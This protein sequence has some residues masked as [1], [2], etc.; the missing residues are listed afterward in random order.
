MA[1]MKRLHGTTNI[2]YGWR[3]GDAAKSHVE[4][5]PAG[6]QPHSFKVPTGEKIIDDFVRIEVK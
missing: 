2:T 4:E 5:I 3:E 6:D 1:F